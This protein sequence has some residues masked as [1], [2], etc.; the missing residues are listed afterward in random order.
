MT[1]DFDRDT[2]VTEQG[3]GRY[4]ALV[5][6][7][8]NVGPVPNGG[9]V[10]TLAL[11][12]IAAALPGRDP[13][14][15]TAHYLRPA[16]PGPLEIAVELVKQGK[17]L[18]TAEARLLQGGREVTRVLAT[19]GTL[20]AA[21]QRFVDAEP[22]PMPAPEQALA[23]PAGAPGV[24][25]ANRFEQRFDPA[26]VRWATGER[27]KGGPAELR[28]WQRFVDGRAPDAMSLPLFADS[29]PP[30]VFAVLDPGWVPTIELTVHVRA[31]PAPGWL[32]CRFRTRFVFGGYLEEDGEIWDE[33]GQL[34]ALSRQ[35]AAVPSKTWK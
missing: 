13:L 21:G 18:A 24:E 28:A 11:R 8:W 34:V 9:Y 16:V 25:I 35:L 33:A 5:S 17:T 27:E 15:L 1:S 19:L 6:P 7:R 2:A 12:A 22:P 29:M 10:M 4:G 31:R 20:D 23:R 26:T 3:P 14:T 30:P 32:R